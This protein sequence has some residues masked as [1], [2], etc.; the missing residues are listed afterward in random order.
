LFSLSSSAVL[1]FPSP[2]SSPSL[3]RCERN[4]AL[5][6]CNFTSPFSLFFSSPLTDLL[7]RLRRPL[8]AK[9]RANTAQLSSLISTRAEGNAATSTDRALRSS[10]APPLSAASSLRRG[11]LTFSLSFSLS[12]LV[13]QSPS[14]FESQT[15]RG[16]TSAISKLLSP[17]VDSTALKPAGPARDRR[18]RATE[19]PSV[20]S[21]E[22]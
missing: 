22:V 16:G 18:P 11:R 10:L 15:Y 20:S 3:L 9:T 17:L 21:S 4:V 1:L 2:R 13:R 5:A 19:Q 6:L 7:P 12:P 14:P 8:L